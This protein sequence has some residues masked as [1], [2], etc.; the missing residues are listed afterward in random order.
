MLDRGRNIGIIFLYLLGFYVALIAFGL[1]PWL[2]LIG[3]LGFGLG[4]YNIIIIEAGHITKAWAMA[5]MAP[6]LAGMVLALRAATK[7]WSDKKRRRTAARCGDCCC[8]RCR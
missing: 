4:S 1:N 2:A 3:A 5:M 6:I 8:S 7:R